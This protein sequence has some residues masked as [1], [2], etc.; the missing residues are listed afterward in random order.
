LLQVSSL[1][2]AHGRGCKEAADSAPSSDGGNYNAEGGDG[3][4]VPPQQDGDP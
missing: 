4:V 2:L 1:G 3:H